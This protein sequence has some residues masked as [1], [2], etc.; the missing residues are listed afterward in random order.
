[1]LTR[2]HTDLPAT[3]TF[4]HNWNEPY[5]PLLPSHRASRHFPSRIGQEAE[6]AWMTGCIPRWF[7]HPKMV[8]HPST[9]RSWRRVTCYCYCSPAAQHVS[10]ADACRRRSWKTSRQSCSSRSPTCSWRSSASLTCKRRWRTRFNMTQM[11]STATTGY[12]VTSLPLLLT[13]VLQLPST[14][15][16]DWGR[17]PM[18]LE[19]VATV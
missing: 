7:A 9:N 12:L 18:Y 10:V 2:D 17:K 8:T 4:S 5:L 11:S 6:L 1:M 15:H 19:F 14:S 3:H 13:T 16:R